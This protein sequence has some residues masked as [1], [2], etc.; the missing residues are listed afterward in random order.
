MFRGAELASQRAG[1]AKYSRF[2]SGVIG[3]ASIAGL[4]DDRADIDDAASARAFIMGLAAALAES[5]QCA[6][7]GVDYRIPISPLDILRQ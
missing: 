5:K 4:T 6:Q 1:E 7:I 3:L 2:G